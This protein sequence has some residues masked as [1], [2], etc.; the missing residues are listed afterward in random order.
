MFL[1]GPLTKPCHRH[2]R[3]HRAWCT[4]HTT[5][6][7][8][9]AS[10]PANQHPFIQNKKQTE[11][12]AFTADKKYITNRSLFFLTPTK[13]TISH[14]TYPCHTYEDDS[15]SNQSTNRKKT[16]KN[17]YIGHCFK[18][19][20]NLVLCNTSTAAVYMLLLTSYENTT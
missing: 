14:A 9:Q 16:K 19:I 8:T 17:G 2:A 20:T 11:L 7:H 12:V 1:A 18:K 4:Q 6:K 13:H 3:T 10:K 15:F 5:N